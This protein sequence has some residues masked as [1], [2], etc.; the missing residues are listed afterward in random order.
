VPVA[1]DINGT[2]TRGHSYTF[3]F[4]GGFALVN[5]PIPV[6][7]VAELQ[8]WLNPNLATNISCSTSGPGGMQA[9]ISFVFIG[10]SGSAVSDLAEAIMGATNPDGDSGVLGSQLDFLGAVDN[11]VAGPGGTQPASGYFGP[12]GDATQKVVDNT[13]NALPSSSSL[14]AIVVLALFGLFVFSGGATA[15][16]AALAR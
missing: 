2:L 4:A 12:V 9:D 11:T 16:R 10:A 15:T 3:S 13:K 6:V 14:W 5:A 8:P 7:I 1:L